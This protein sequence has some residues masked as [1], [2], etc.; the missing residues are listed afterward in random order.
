MRVDAATRT[1]VVLAAVVAVTLGLREAGAF[2]LP[3]LT[4][5]FLAVISSPVVRWLE[6][7]ARMPG[8]VAILLTLLLDLG[9]V[10]GLGALLWASLAGLQQALPRYER[11]LVSLAHEAVNPLRAWGWDASERI[12]DAVSSA[13]RW[14]NVAHD[15]LQKAGELAGNVVLVVLLLGFMLFE[16]RSAQEKLALLLGRASPH[17][18]RAAHAAAEVQRYL[19]VKTALSAIVGALTGGWALLWGLDVPLLWGLLAFVLNYVPT[20]GPALSLMPPL[21]VAV[22]T[23]GPASAAGYAAGHLAIGFVIGNVIEPRWMGTTLGL[24][25]L[26]VVLAMFFWGWMWGPLGA[27]FA[28]PL[29]MILRSALESVEQ[30]R[31]IAVLLGSRPYVERKRREWGWQTLEERKSRPPPVEAPTPEPEAGSEDAERRRPAA[32]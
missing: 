26:V 11:A 3:A 8:P 24:S 9:L 27:L 22:L 30:T 17:L 1:V 20:L 19:V 7:R 10:A 32:E 16:R 29:T 13:D 21:V 18:E 31:W 14:L 25:T 6:T 2:F 4:A 28:V 5:L 15:V 12:L 23:H